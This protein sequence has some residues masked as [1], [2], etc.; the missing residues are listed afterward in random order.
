MKS[1]VA[2]AMLL[3]AFSAY[4]GA[5]PARAEPPASLCHATEPVL[6]TC[7]IGAKLV[8]ICG[9]EQGGAAYRY[10]QPGRLEL[11]ITDLHRGHEYGSGGGETQVYADTPTH[12]YVVYDRI[13][14][15]GFGVDG[16]HY[17][18]EG[19][20]LLVQSGGRTVWRRQCALPSSY[21]PNTIPEGRFDP[22]IEKLIPEG[23]YVDH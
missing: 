9:Q 17:P 8:S 6:F 23:E 14:R 15:T 20:G 4:L 19:D 2:A 12:R 13:V 3:A 21:D 22:L 16:L 1:I 11:E 10:G 5:A 18:R 7:H